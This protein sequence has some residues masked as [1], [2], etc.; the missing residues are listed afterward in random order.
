MVIPFLQKR[1]IPCFTKVNDMCGISGIWNLD[2]KPVD[3]KQIRLLTDA[4]SHRGPDDSGIWFDNAVGLALGHRRLSIIDLTDAG[5]QPMSYGNGRYWI[6]YNGE[7]YNYIELRNELKKKGHAFK[8]QSDTEVILAAF[9]EWG[10]DSVTRFNGMWGFAIYDLVKKQLF[11]S[12]DRFGIKPFYYYRSPSL[13]AFAS[14]VQALHSMLG[15][16][17][18]LNKAVMQDI[19]A[20]SF[21]NHGT[22]FTYIQNAFVLPA[23]FN[24]FVTID[25][26]HK[27]EWYTL[28]K[29]AVPSNLKKQA[30][31]LMELLTDSCALRLRSDVPVATCLSGGLDSGG[32]TATIKQMIDR[33]NDA[34]TYTHRAFCAAFPGS[35]IDESEAA[36]KLADQFGS[37]LDIVPVESPSPDEL[38]AAMR[39]CDGPMH[40]LA[41]YP[42]WKLYG[43]IKQQNIK[44]TLDGQGPDEMLGG[45]RPIAEGL[46]AAVQMGNPAW[47]F[48]IYR[49]Y[50]LQGETDQFSSKQYARDA[51]Y[52]LFKIAVK[53]ALHVNRKL[54]TKGEN[55]NTLFFAKK[56]PFQMNYFDNSLFC[57]SFQQ[58][59]PGILN[60][61]DRCSMAHGVECRMPYM[62]FRIVEFIFSLPVQSK[63]GGG[64]TKRVLREALKGT[65][66]DSTRLNR[67]KIGFNAPIVDWF[68]N[69]LK[70]WMLG[71]INSNAFLQSEYFNGPL[72]KRNFDGFLNNP[73]PQWDYTWQ[74]WPP[75]HITWWLTNLKENIN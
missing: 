7:V 41:F 21:L 18:E 36:Q 33:S 62:D 53:K 16:K 25:S 71:F 14:E 59:L 23:G 32:I 31:A 24:A 67:L 65:L 28:R 46:V 49:T 47:F 20:G 45:Y 3:S 6:T 8:T 57:Q 43:Y 19:A 72:K 42:I 51:V 61:Y 55:S 44:V 56:P 64:Y 12:R 9:A 70:E 69:P 39:A 10:A 37:K 58:P 15:N 50:S 26:F 68:K 40:A 2:K 38:E 13:F 35:P 30:V 29:V 75:V 74:F 60:Q 52:N 48:D 22:E 17:H 63:V 66:P 34:G 27:T 4:Q 54:P 5:K 1:L 11:L 73:R